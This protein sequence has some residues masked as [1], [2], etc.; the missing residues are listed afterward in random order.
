MMKMCLLA[1]FGHLACTP[2]ADAQ[3]ASRTGSPEQ[4]YD[5]L[6]LKKITNI[7]M[8][9]HFF[10]DAPSA[11]LKVSGKIRLIYSNLGNNVFNP[12]VNR[13]L[14]IYE[15]DADRGREIFD[16]RISS[17]T[18]EE[19]WINSIET[20]DSFGAFKTFAGK[21][22][23]KYMLDATTVWFDNAYI[24]NVYQCPGG[25]LV[26]FVH[27]ESSKGNPTENPA[28]PPGN[29]WFY[30]DR[31]ANSVR[32]SIGIAYS[33]DNGEH[34]SYCG[35][36]ICSGNQDGNC[37][38]NNIGGI[39]YVVHND[40][41]YVYFNEFDAGNNRRIGVARAKAG[42]VIAAAQ[43][44]N[45]TLWEKYTDPGWSTDALASGNYGA[46]IVPHISGISLYDTHADAAYC[47]PLSTFLLLAQT[48]GNGK[49]LLY[50]SYDGLH[51]NSNPAYLDDNYDCSGTPVVCTEQPHAFFVSFNLDGSN[52][53][54]IVGKEFYV[55]YLHQRT[56]ENQ[57]LLRKK[58]TVIDNGPAI[59]LLLQ[60]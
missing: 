47:S 22:F 57:T 60:D 31:G 54:T 20:V 42:D 51:W 53:C 16:T 59:N 33:G 56:Y 43:A 6:A 19:C 52:D 27:I 44:G 17:K 26:G 3:L 46:D 5:N 48:S 49:L 15:C 30:G 32:Y 45:V 40:S 55:Y 18:F 10:I 36:V 39:P 21:K 2:G 24:P 34:W 58:L 25:G 11:T 50:S 35:D 28:P 8:P 29:N 9:D 7:A 14:D 23:R 38:T 13:G 1:F 4:C 41:L 12:P 37:G